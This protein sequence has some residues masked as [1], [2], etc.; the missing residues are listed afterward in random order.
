ML[1]K[2]LGQDSTILT[3]SIVVVC[4]ES[5]MNPV[6]SGILDPKK[7]MPRKKKWKNIYM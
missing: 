5:T 4:M 6:P 2:N 3:S 1:A 7:D